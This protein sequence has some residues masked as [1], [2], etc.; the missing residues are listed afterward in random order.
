[1]ADMAA[2]KPDA[3]ANM[4]EDLTENF[5]KLSSDESYVD[6]QDEDERPESVDVFGGK[7]M[8]DYPR[9]HFTVPTNNT[10]AVDRKKTEPSVKSED[11]VGCIPIEEY[12]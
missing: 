8:E 1:M 4:M 9:T 2:S 6:V 7:P 11:V 5:Q 10:Q 12:P 3:L